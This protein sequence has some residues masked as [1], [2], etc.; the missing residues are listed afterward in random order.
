MKEI[1]YDVVV[2]GLILL[3]LVV[4][5]KIYRGNMNLIDTTTRK[6]EETNLVTSSVVSVDDEGQAL[7]IVRG[8]EVRKILRNYV[9]ITSTEE[10]PITVNGTTYRKSVLNDVNIVKSYIADGGD[11]N[12]PTFNNATF[13]HSVTKDV[14]GKMIGIV[15]TQN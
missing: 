6:S 4:A 9:V 1:V 5:I 12:R 10:I 7:A 13:N 2:A 8:A 14:D 11:F 15:F 3:I